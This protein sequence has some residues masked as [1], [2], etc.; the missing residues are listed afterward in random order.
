[1]RGMGYIEY[2]EYC[3]KIYKESCDTMKKQGLEPCVDLRG[4]IVG[5]IGQVSE[6]YLAPGEIEN[7]CDDVYL[8][9]VGEGV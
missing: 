3:S 9:I 2:V 7:F 8:D 6:T 1:M 5:N 4:I